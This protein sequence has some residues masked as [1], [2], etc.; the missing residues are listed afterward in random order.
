MYYIYKITNI[1]NNKIYIGQVYNKTIYDRFKRHCADASPLAPSYIDRAINKYGSDNFVVEEIDTAENKEELN[2][3]EKYWISFYNSTNHNIGYNLTDGGDGGN[4]YA[5]KSEEEL[6]QVKKKISVMLTGKNNGMSKQIKALNKNTGEILHF[7]T[8]HE[9]CVYFKIKQKGAF[10]YHA[11][12][13][14]TCWWR[15]EWTFA[16]E[17]N[18]F[19]QNLE[20]FDD[21]C[22]KGQKIKV[23][24]KDTNEIL[25]FNSKNKCNSFFSQ[26]LKYNTDG[27]PIEVGNYIVSK[28]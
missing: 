7:Q 17:E 20:V 11:N 12:G 19:N 9:A 3:K 6:K 26:N 23:V 18:E 13:H 8:L 16:Y 22:R 24:N 4:T 1:V 27:S 15:G 14:A 28:I 2:N 10:T 21:S 5:Y 25:F